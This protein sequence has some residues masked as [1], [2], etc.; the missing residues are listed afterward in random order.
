MDAKAIR[1]FIEEHPGGIAVLMIDGTVYRVPGRDWLWL[2]PDFS[3]A[4]TKSPRP[5]TSFYLFDEDAG[6]LRLVNSML[7]KEL[8]PLKSNGNKKGKGR[9][10]SA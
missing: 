7:V 2:T 3:G 6:H 8:Q 9:R 1:T 4:T 5:A 10:K